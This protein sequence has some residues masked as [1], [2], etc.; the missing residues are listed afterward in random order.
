[1]AADVATDE[2][3][4]AEEQQP[5]YGHIKEHST[6]PDLGMHFL[7]MAKTVE[8]AERIIDKSTEPFWGKLIRKLYLDGFS[9]D[10]MEVKYCAQD[11][12]RWCHLF[13]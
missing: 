2:K 3:K 12:T 4:D 9:I 13:F 7:D 8:H 5:Q 10:Q 6:I 11:D 1:M